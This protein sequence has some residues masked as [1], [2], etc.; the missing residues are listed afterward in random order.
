MCCASDGCYIFHT[1]QDS[2]NWWYQSV[3]H[4]TRQLGT[5]LGAPEC[6]PCTTTYERQVKRKAGFCITLSQH[7]RSFLKRDGD[8]IFH[9]Q[10]DMTS[11]DIN[12]FKVDRGA[13]HKR[14]AWPVIFGL[15]HPSFMIISYPKV[16]HFTNIYTYNSNFHKR[17]IVTSP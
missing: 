3:V 9:L 2:H 12:L 8:G 16:K 6:E 5:L 11:A 4:G 13:Q 14:C 17:I 10:I 1:A 7:Q 15:P